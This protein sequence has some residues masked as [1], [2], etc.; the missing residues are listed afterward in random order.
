MK[1]AV[2]KPN[3]EFRVILF[4]INQQKGFWYKAEPRE[5]KVFGIV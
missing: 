3:L 2:M 4:L 5:A 1:E